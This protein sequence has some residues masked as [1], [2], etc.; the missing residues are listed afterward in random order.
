MINKQVFVSPVTYIGPIGRLAIGWGVYESVADECK[1]AGIKK[2]LITTT[3]LKGTG[4]VDE[5]KGILSHNSIAHE[6]YDKVTTNPKDYQIMEAYEVLKETGCDGV[7]SVGG[8]SS[9]DCGKGAR[10]L[11]ANEGKSICDFSISQ[12]WMEAEKH[13]AG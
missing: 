8:G 4:I 2:A 13:I 10:V 5:I 6:V 7:V 12:N 3:G 9:H 11:A 1:K